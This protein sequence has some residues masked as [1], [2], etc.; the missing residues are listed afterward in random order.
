MVEDCEVTKIVILE[1]IRACARL[2]T[3]QTTP[4][5]LAGDLEK[6]SF[7]LPMKKDRTYFQEVDV[8]CFT[9]S[10]CLSIDS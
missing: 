10:N 6:R 1:V 9:P 3:L 7:L 8:A 4:C 2:S 5:L